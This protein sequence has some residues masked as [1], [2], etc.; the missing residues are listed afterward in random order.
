MPTSHRRIVT[1]YL[2]QE[3]IN[4][5]EDPYP[6]HMTILVAQMLPFAIYRI[7]QSKRLLMIKLKQTKNA[8]VAMRQRKTTSYTELKTG[9]VSSNYS[10][11]QQT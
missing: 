4:K 10:Q 1:S 6:S 5:K 9:P 7:I 2:N 3:K 8:L 11:S